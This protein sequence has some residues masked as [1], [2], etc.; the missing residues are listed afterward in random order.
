[1]S[2]I[3]PSMIKKKK[4]DDSRG[5]VNEGYFWKGFKEKWWEGS[6]KMKVDSAQ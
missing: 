5:Q 6:G 1:M 3:L 2:E 4:K